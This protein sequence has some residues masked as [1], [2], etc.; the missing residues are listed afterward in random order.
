MAVAFGPFRRTEGI[1]V[2]AIL[3]HSPR[4][5]T[6]KLIIDDIRWTLSP[7]GDHLLRTSEFALKHLLAESR[8]TRVKHGPHRS[9]YRVQLGSTAAYLKHSRIWTLRSFLREILRGPKAR[10]EFDRANLL[11]S[12][13]IPTAVPLAWGTRDSFWPG[14]SYLLTRELPRTE[15]LNHYLER[16]FA[17]GR[18]ESQ[19]LRSEIARALGGYLARV[20]EAG[21]E[22]SDLHPGNLLIHRAGNGIQFYLLDLHDLGVGGPLSWRSSRANLAIF[23]RWFLM[24]CSR[25]D[26][27]RFWRAYSESRRL[28]RD[29]ATR[30]ESETWASNQRF[31]RSRDLRCLRNNRYFQSVRGRGTSGFAVKEMDPDFLKELLRNPDAPFEDSSNRKLKDSRSSTVVELTMP[32]PQG[33]RA[34]I[35]KRF[36]VTSWTDGLANLFRRS[37]TLRSWQHGHGLADRGLSTA[38]PWLVLHRRRWGTPREGYLLCEKIENARELQDHIESLGV[39]AKRSLIEKL[40]RRIRRLHQSGLSHRDLKAA[41]LLITPD[42]EIHFIDLVGVRSRNR[43]L[44]KARVQNLCRLNASFLSA[45]TISRTD[46]LRFLLTYLNAGL[47]RGSH[48]RDWWNEVA[49]A[50]G[51]KIRRNRKRGRPL[52]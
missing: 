40:A 3:P 46:R 32:T 1:G 35:Y 5:G 38:R 19:E 11:L 25:A 39:A 51:E 44:T 9:V 12:R 26:R 37:P 45:T 52:I 49:Q 20:H 14:E 43:I 50:T 34:M 18:T 16:M 23:N 6:S 48:W 30:I 8:A 17:E 41:N 28:S 13:G 36:R 42:G 24:R 15:Q 4:A 2:N 21:I 22:H 47:H 7:E 10:L 31:W 27:F 29:E 33:T